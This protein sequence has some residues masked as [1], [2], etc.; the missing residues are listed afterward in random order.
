[1]AGLRSLY[2]RWQIAHYELQH[3]RADEAHA[4]AEAVL[5]AYGFTAMG[6]SDA[7]LGRRR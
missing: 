5:G 4:R 6:P 1:M 2:H 7:V 3:H